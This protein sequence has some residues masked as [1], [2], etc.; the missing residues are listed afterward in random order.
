[1]KKIL[2]PMIFAALMLA[3]TQAFAD[4]PMKTDTTTG[5]QKLMMKQCMAKHKAQDS[6]MSKDDMKSAC[7]A[8]IK[9]NSEHM[10]NNNS[11]TDNTPPKP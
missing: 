5:N 4:E 3:G 6:S 10:D 7:K 2:T 11:H 9:M 1:M 8:E